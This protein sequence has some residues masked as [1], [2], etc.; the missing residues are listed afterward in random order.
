MAAF[1]ALSIGMMA[2]SAY[3]QYRSGRAAAKAE[4]EAGEAQRRAAEAQA[5]LAEFNASVADLQAKDAVL[6]GQDEENRFRAGVDQLIS[7]Q[8][9]GFAASNVDVGYGSAVDTQADAAFLGE[10]DALT[11]RTNAGREA[12]GYRVE[13]QDLRERARIGREEGVMLE[14]AGRQRASAQNWATASS[15]IGIGATYLTSRYGFG[16]GQQAGKES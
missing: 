10:L 11:I 6:R 15:L 5:Q 12:W 14:A 4:R 13:A 8:R 9:V 2:Y 7:E 16:R 3:S 1:T